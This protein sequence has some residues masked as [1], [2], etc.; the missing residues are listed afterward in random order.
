[1]QQTMW[2]GNI[3]VYGTGNLPWSSACALLGHLMLPSA[4]PE[5]LSCR[6]FST[7]FLQPQEGTKASG[8]KVGNWHQPQTFQ[9]ML[10]C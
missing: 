7:T 6:H 2:S 10:V 5:V 1:M 9:T 3:S 4:Q 8:P